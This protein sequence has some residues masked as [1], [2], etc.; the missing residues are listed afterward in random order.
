MLTIASVTSSDVRYWCI[1]LLR[2]FLFP[3]AG[4]LTL[5]YPVQYYLTIGIVFGIAMLLTGIAESVFAV[6]DSKTSVGGWYLFVSTADMVLCLIL[7][8]NIDVSLAIMPVV[9]SFSSK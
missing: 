3:L 8:M 1:Y 9:I 7:I 5:K 4:F 6:P 2:A